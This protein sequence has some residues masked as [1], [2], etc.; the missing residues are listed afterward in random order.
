MIDFIFKYLNR[1]FFRRFL[2]LLDNFSAFTYMRMSWINY[3]Q[4]RKNILNILFK[5]LRQY[6]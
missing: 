1:L 5:N 2:I 4:D 6:F 3:F